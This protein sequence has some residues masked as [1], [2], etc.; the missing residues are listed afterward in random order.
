MALTQVLGKTVR[1]DTGRRVCRGVAVPTIP[2]LSPQLPW[3][4]SNAAEH[5]P[6]R[7]SLNH[8]RIGRNDYEPSHV[9]G[10][11][12]A[13]SFTYVGSGDKH[14]LEAPCNLTH[15]KVERHTLE[16]SISGCGACKAPSNYSLKRE[17]LQL[18]I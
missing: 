1:W 7:L 9:K 11:A 12:L 5:W 16:S 8:Q 18:L 2:C 15:S 10:A 14:S 13:F 3:Q 6:R 4:L 17:P